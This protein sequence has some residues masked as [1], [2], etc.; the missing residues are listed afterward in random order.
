MGTAGRYAADVSANLA[1]GVAEVAKQRTSA[2][3]SAR[4]DKTF[5]GQVA[6][7][8][9]RQGGQSAGETAAEPTFAGDSLSAGEPSKRDEEVNDFVN[10]KSSSA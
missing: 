2:A 7:A 5:G 8:I 10:K 3:I 1:K 6:A 4:V 9:R